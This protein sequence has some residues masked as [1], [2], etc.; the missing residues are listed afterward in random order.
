MAP[1][2]NDNNI[3][4]L[5]FMYIECLPLFQAHIVAKIGNAAKLGNTANASKIRL[6]GNRLLGASSP[7]VS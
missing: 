3:A 2:T 7:K 5:F 6:L 1:A 4:I